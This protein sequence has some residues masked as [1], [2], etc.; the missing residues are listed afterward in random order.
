MWRKFG[1]VWSGLSTSHY[2]KRFLPKRKLTVIC[3]LCENESMVNLWLFAVLVCRSCFLLLEEGVAP[4]D[5]LDETEHLGLH[6]C[7]CSSKGLTLDIIADKI[8]SL[9]E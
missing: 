6:R 8:G 3:A 7:C 5:E 2:E 9:K 1:F 4:D